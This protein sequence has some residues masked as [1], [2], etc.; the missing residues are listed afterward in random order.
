[1]PNL[2]APVFEYLGFQPQ[3]YLEYGLNKMTPGYEQLKSAP[4]GQLDGIYYGDY[5]GSFLVTDGKYVYTSPVWNN[6]DE[7]SRLELLKVDP[8]DCAIGDVECLDMAKYSDLLDNL[9]YMEPEELDELSDEELEKL[10]FWSSVKKVAKKG[11][12]KGKKT[13]KKGVKKGGKV[14]KKGVN[15]GGKVLKQGA[16]KGMKAAKPHV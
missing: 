6:L 13:L 15:K 5:Q 2:D 7:A 10:L 4:D 11:Y 12:K 3:G 14:L 9:E 8:E 16:K 1:M